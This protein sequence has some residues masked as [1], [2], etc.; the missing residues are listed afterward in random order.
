MDAKKN[1]LELISEYTLIL[2]PPLYE[3]VKDN[4]EF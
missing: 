4:S 1:Q 3:W 2:L